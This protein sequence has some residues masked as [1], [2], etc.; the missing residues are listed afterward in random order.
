MNNKIIT[1][2]GMLLLIFSPTVSNGG[3]SYKP[4]VQKQYSINDFSITHSDFHHGNVVIKI[5]QAKKKADKYNEPPYLCRAWLDVSK[6]KNR[7]YQKYFDDIDA[8]GFSYGLFVPKIQ[9]PSPYFAVVKNGDYDG[10][11]FLVRKDG[12]VFDLMGGFFFITKNRRYLFSEYASDT[13]GLAVFDLR[14]GRVVF[15]SMELPAEMSHWYE[16]KGEY[17]FTA[18]P[19]SYNVPDKIIAYFYDFSANK[20]IERTISGAELADSIPVTYDFDPR[21]YENCTTTANKRI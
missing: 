2:I 16:K 3:D 7:I 18:E 5:I 13:T 6:A 12:K 11:L 19:D 10:K 20:I 9:P 14:N 21:E 8:V 15:S 1:A 4:Y 17:Y